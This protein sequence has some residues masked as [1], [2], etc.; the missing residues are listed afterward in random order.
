[1][2]SKANYCNLLLGG[3]YIWGYIEI[4]KSI[5][6]QTHCKP[7]ATLWHHHWHGRAYG[8]KT[9]PHRQCWLVFRNFTRGRQI[10]AA[11]VPIRRQGKTTRCPM[12]NNAVLSALHRTDYGK[13][14]MSGRGL[15]AMA[16]TVL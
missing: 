14:E 1:M 4:V 12:R 7:Y 13:D 16:R 3:G 2:P 10:V 5:Y 11:Q 6:P 8:Q 9:K 15:R